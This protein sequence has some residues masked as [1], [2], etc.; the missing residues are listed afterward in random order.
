VVSWT[1]PYGRILGLL[2]R[3]S[4]YFFHVVLSCSQEVD[5][6]PFQTHCLSGNLVA[7]GIEPAPLDL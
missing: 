1:D 2:D 6:T 4:Y 3:S 7:S 5:W